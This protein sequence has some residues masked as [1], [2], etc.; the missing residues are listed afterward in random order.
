MAF[1]IEFELTSGETKVAEVTEY[2]YFPEVLNM[3]K[4]LI[5]N[6]GIYKVHA[7]SF[8]GDIIR[9]SFIVGSHIASFNIVIRSD[10]QLGGI[11]VSNSVYE[12]GEITCENGHINKWQR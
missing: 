1:F 2:E 5:E 10:E 3:V 12:T 4:E 8:D 9:D 11:S 6:N 7:H